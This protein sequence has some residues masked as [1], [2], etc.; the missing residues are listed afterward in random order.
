MVLLDLSA[1]FDTVDHTELLQTLEELGRVGSALEWLEFYLRGRRQVVCIG[2]AFSVPQ[3]MD[4]GVPQGSVLRLILFTVY[5]SSLGQ[6]LREH[7]MKYHLYADDP[8]GN[9][10]VERL[11]K[12]VAAVR[13]WMTRKSLKM[14]D[15]KTEVLL[16]SSSRLAR[17]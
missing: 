6:L 13:R 12:C 9:S 8:S 11:E 1:A 7:D 14:N 17:R 16:I 3:V 5:T 15:S 4:C 10:T 2:S